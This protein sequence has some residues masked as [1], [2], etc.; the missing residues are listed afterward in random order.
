MKKYSTSLN[1]V[2]ILQT[3]SHFEII[4]KYSVDAE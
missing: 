2:K 4:P 3:T 1:F